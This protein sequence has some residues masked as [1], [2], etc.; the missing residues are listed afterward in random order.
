M[1]G[2]LK[3]ARVGKLFPVPDFLFFV[4]VG[5]KEKNQELLAKFEDRFLEHARQ[6]EYNGIRIGYVVSPA[7]G[8]IELVY[9]VLDKY[10]LFSLSRTV[11]KASID[12]FQGRAVSL[13]A[14]EAFKSVHLADYARSRAVQFIRID[15]TIRQLQNVLAW[16][17]TRQ[18]TQAAR[19]AAFQEGSARRLADAA[20]DTR[21][22]EQELAETQKRI[23]ALNDEIGELESEQVDAAMRR[24][25]REQ[26]LEKVKAL[27]AGIA[28]ARARQKELEEIQR[29]Y[30]RFLGE[31]GD[32]EEI[33]ANVVAP[34]LKSFMSLKSWGVRTT[35]E[36]GAFES[37]VFLKVE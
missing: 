21:S 27:E 28:D 19:K 4:K 37:S 16:V 1:G 33:E 29:G 17:K 14:S 23:T 9:C 36:T 18:A 8:E 24:A 25:D 5:D 35:L 7:Q 31:R 20:R 34:L 22:Q 13:T 15:E 26:S 32:R 3:G 6:E 30:D 12:T 11:I 2:Y 10:L